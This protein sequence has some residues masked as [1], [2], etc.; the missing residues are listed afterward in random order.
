MLRLDK[1]I[2]WDILT[3]DASVVQGGYWGA[4]GSVRVRKIRSIP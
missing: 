1:Y 2:T 3:V 4:K